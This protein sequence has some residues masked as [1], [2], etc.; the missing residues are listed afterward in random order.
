MPF[1][2][3][4]FIAIQMANNGVLRLEYGLTFSQSHG[5]THLSLIMFRHVYN[6]WVRCVRIKLGRVGIL[7]A[8]YISCKLNDSALK[9]QANSQQRFLSGSSPLSSGNFAF[10]ASLTKATGNK[11]TLTLAQS[12]PGFMKLNGICG[13]GGIFEIRGSDISKPESM[14][15][16]KRCMIKCF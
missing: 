16:S 7:F 12:F 3:S 8:Q 11:D 4:V 5:T 13:L 10:N 14:I 6:H 1:L 15:E 2:Y 9:S